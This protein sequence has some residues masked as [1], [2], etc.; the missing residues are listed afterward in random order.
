MAARWKRESPDELLLM[1]AHNR[2]SRWN[3]F[4]FESVQELGLPIVCRTFSN[5]WD[6]STDTVWL[7]PRGKRTA[8]V[9]LAHSLQEAYWR[10]QEVE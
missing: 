5:H 1:H 3:Y 7:V 10:S 8:V 2:M 9:K 6:G 4:L